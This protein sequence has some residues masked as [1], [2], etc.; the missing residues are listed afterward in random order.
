MKRR[1]V[2]NMTQGVIWKQILQFFFPILVGAL[3]QQLYNTVD[4]VVVG[5]FAGKEALASVGGSAAQILNFVFS[6]FIGLST[7]S[8]VMIAQYFGADKP[9][10]VDIALHTSY[11]FSP[12]GGLILGGIGVLCT[13]PLLRLLG[14]PDELMAQSAAYVRILFAGMVLTLIFNMGSGILRA[15]GDA[16]R[17]LY[18]LMICC[19]MNIFLDMLFVIVFRMGAAGAA[20]A[21]NISQAVSA[22][23]VTWLLAYRTEGM[24]LSFRRLR[25]DRRMLWRILQIGVP[26]AFAG[27]MFS[28]SNMIIQAAV[29][30]MGVDSIAAWTAYGKIDALWWMIDQAFSTTVVTF[31]GQNYGAGLP[32]RIRR[33]TQEMLM[34]EILMAFSCTLFMNVC[35]EP[36]LCLFTTDAAVIDLGVGLIRFLTPYYA[37]FC[38]NE[39]LSSTLR[40]EG[41]VMVSTVANLIGICAY[42]AVWVIFFCPAGSTLK[43]VL[44]CYPVSWTLISLFITVYFWLHQSAILRRMDW[45]AAR[46]AKAGQV[47]G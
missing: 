21:T 15:V 22:V 16:K 18:I 42:R 7:G 40:A 38:L 17:P 28:I 26:T 34:I 8:T 1:T 5:Q 46:R 35:G 27:S 45:H 25:I 32:N 44:T 4:A 33:G 36:L 24:K 37:I 2:R 3:F 31:V 19:I 6:F 23:L 11:A 13:T 41:Y 20:I 30:R 47:S 39:V 43:R 12:Y 10:D 14:T 29:N 9:D